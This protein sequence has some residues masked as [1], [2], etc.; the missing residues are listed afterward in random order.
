MK[1]AAVGH[2]I[3]PTGRMARP[4]GL[5]LLVFVWCNFTMQRNVTMEDARAV[6]ALVQLIVCRLQR[7]AHLL[8]A[9]RVRT[10]RKCIDIGN[11]PFDLL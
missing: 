5:W 2:E 6:H 1:E 3:S 4:V 9:P 8:E 11:C 10:R 7:G